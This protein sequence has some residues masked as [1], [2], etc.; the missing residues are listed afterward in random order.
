MI[1]SHY[2]R[3]GR[4]FSC[5]RYADENTNIHEKCIKIHKQNN[6]TDKIRD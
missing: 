4:R 3:V 2:I 6:K 1:K 5:C